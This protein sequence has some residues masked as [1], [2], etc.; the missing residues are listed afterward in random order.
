MTLCKEFRAGGNNK[1]PDHLINKKHGVSRSRPFLR[2]SRVVSC[3][4]EDF[5]CD[6]Q[7]L[8]VCSGVGTV[9]V[10]FLAWENITM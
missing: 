5:K 9:R 4:F 6:R 8:E 10:R 3:I 7:L 2:I 1:V